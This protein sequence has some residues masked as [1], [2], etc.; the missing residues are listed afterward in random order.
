MKLIQNMW[1]RKRSTKKSVTDNIHPE[2]STP[3]QAPT[4]TSTEL[5]IQPVDSLLPALTENSSDKHQDSRTTSSNTAK[6]NP[7]L[8]H[9]VESVRAPLHVTNPFLLRKECNRGEEIKSEN[10][11]ERKEISGEGT[12]ISEAPAFYM[13]GDSASNTAIYQFKTG[14]QG[15]ENGR[16]DVD[17]NVKSNQELPQ[18]HQPKPITPPTAMQKPSLN[19][20]SKYQFDSDSEDE[21]DEIEVEITGKLFEEIEARRKRVYGNIRQLKITEEA[22]RNEIASRV[23]CPCTNNSNINERI[24]LNRAR[25]NRIR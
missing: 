5:F 13:H 14:S 17:P 1:R 22:R 12:S 10:E 18:N 7:F 2:A 19:P 21:D 9:E 4:F 24:L 6:K 20:R 11:D 16:R 25:L 3:A 15:D 8:A 23:D